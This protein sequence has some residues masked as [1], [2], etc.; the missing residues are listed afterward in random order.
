MKGRTGLVGASIVVVLALLGWFS[1]RES[2]PNPADS[3]TG[4]MPGMTMGDTTSD[5]ADHG[6][7]G[8]SGGHSG[9]MTGMK[10]LV[11]GANGTRASAAG[12]TL[13]PKR[14]VFSANQTTQWQLRVTDRTGMTVTKFERDQTKLMHLIVVRTDLTEY[15]HLHPVL[16]RGGVFA[17]DLHL[18]RPGSYR[19]IADFTT[20]GQRYALGVPIVVPGGGEQAPLP[21]ESASTKVDGFSVTTMHA[22]P[23]VGDETEIRFTIHRGGKPVTALLPY[24]GAY[25]HL[26]ALRKPDISYSHVH[27]AS[28]DRANGLIGFVV[29]FAA[30]GAYRLFLQFRTA[31][32][33]HTAPF[34]INVRS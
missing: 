18:P 13:E 33:I 28:E 34:T 2:G 22:D 19:A 29:D 17:I 8:M 32:G 6:M 7:P 3:P 1:I 30:S 27:P 31:S 20:G 21:D 15:Q 26:V 14:A 23:K 11:A 9:G 16:G 25:G 5:T 10:P 4:A 12:L 24:L